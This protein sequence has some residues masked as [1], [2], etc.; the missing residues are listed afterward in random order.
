[1]TFNKQKKNTEELHREK[2]T[3]FHF[4][5]KQFPIYCILVS[6]TSWESNA[7]SAA[8]GIAWGQDAG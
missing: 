2:L 8:Q 3:C 5:Q 6:E 1:M 4:T 7:P